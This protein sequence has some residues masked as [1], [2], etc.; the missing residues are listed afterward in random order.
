MTWEGVPW[1]VGGGARH[2][3]EAARLL[4]FHAVDGAEGVVGAGALAVVPLAVP[5]AGFRVMPGAG[6]VLNRAVGGGEQAYLVRNPDADVVMVSGTGSSGGRTDLVAVV[7]EDP[8]YAGQPVPVS[9]PDGP[10]VRTKVYT[11]V[12]AT[13]TTLA[14]VDPNQTGLALALLTWDVSDATLDAASI[15][16]LRV[17]S[18]SRTAGL[19]RALALA[20][21]AAVE[22][23]TSTTYVT[24]PS[25]ATWTVQI[26]SWA[27]RASLE[28]YAG[29]VQTVDDTVDG[30]NWRGSVRVAL[31]SVV[32]AAGGINEES[33]GVG[34]VD[35]LTY[36]AAQDVTI[37]KA[38]RGQSVVLRAEAKQDATSGGLALRAAPGTTVV[39]KATFYEAPDPSFWQA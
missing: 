29:G 19:T 7:V 22:P 34:R 23:L 25:A 31:G 35:T 38:L 21:G 20:P 37:P 28:L 5:G 27:V 26:P 33:S 24:F 13:V 30:G 8:Q 17:L 9:V 32:T 11:G 6:A 3:P 12:P 14:E 1:A 36:M 10:Y 15:K 18:S 2:S 16:D 4:A 39:C